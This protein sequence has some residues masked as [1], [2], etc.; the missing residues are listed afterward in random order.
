VLRRRPLPLREVA[1]SPAHALVT[2]QPA[3]SAAALRLWR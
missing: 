1:A 2:E 3:A